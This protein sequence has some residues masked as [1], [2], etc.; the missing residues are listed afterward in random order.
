MKVIKIRVWEG[1][2]YVS[3]SY[4]LKHGLVCVQEDFEDQRFNEI[5]SCYEH[6]IMEQFTGRN[7]CNGGEIYEGDIFKTMEGDVAWFLLVFFDSA[8][9]GFRL[10]PREYSVLNDEDFG[11]EDFEDYCM[12]KME[13]HSNIHD[14][15][16]TPTE[17]TGNGN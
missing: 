16:S 11:V 4:A 3:L 17:V 2:K 12:D 14:N 5:E 13:V 15:Q 6:V 10:R 9:C 7:D 8:T 1:E